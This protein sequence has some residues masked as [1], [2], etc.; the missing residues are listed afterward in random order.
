MP[1]ETIADKHPIN[2]QIF[3]RKLRFRY[4]R[5]LCIIFGVQDQVMA[6]LTCLRSVE[7]NLTLT[8]PQNRLFLT[9]QI[10]GDT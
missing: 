10:L 4:Q 1:N 8:S 3:W 9:S 2:I 6:A 7:T 5:I